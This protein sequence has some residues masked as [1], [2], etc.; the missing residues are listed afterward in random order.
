MAGTQ[1]RL[2]LIKRAYDLVAANCSRD[3]A[4]A[5]TAAE[6]EAI[7]ESLRTLESAFLKAARSGLDRQ[8]DEVEN[9][10][11]AADA[12][13]DALHNSYST[14]A[15]LPDRIRAIRQVS[16]TVSLFVSAADDD[17]WGGPRIAS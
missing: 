14:A 12:A 3:I 1:D 9:A 10:Y 17:G 13:T 11:A 5:S 4:D 2:A 6:T 7:L 15:A 16:K 8:G